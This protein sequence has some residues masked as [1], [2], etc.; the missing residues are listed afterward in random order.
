MFL[1]NLYDAVQV[2]GVNNVKLL[3][4]HARMLD[5]QAS[6]AV[7]GSACVAP[8][9]VWVTLEGGG[10]WFDKKDEN[11]LMA[12]AWDTLEKDNNINTS[13]LERTGDSDTGRS[14]SAEKVRLAYI[15]SILKQYRRQQLSMRVQSL[16]ASADECMSGLV[17]DMIHD[18]NEFRDMQD[19]KITQRNPTRDPLIEH[20]DKIRRLVRILR[21][22]PVCRNNFCRTAGCILRYNLCLMEGSACTTKRLQQIQR[23]MMFSQRAWSRFMVANFDE[24]YSDVRKVYNVEDSIYVYDWAIVEMRRLDS[25]QFNLLPEA[26]LVDPESNGADNAGRNAYPYL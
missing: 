3:A 19:P 15:S 23:E 21:R 26:V 10:D 2:E 13:M 22:L 12:V 7:A 5:K 1:G 6:N 11:R 17:M 14:A 8:A 4:Q 25:D 9:T 18:Y 24:I 16:S 20:D